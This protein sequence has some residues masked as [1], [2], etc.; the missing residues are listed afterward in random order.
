MK[1]R[2]NNKMSRNN[3]IPLFSVHIPKNASKEVSKVIESGDINRGDKVKEFEDLF[4]QM[5]GCDYALAVNSC[6]SALRLAYSLIDRRDKNGRRNIF[7]RDKVVTTPYTMVATNTAMME[8]GFQPRFADIQY[9]TANIDP[10]DIKRKIDESTKAI[11]VVHYAGYLCDWRDV[12]EI[13]RQHELLL[14]EDCAHALGASWYGTDIASLQSECISNIKC[15]S[16]QAIKHITTCGDGGM[17]VTSEK[18]LYE[19]AKTKAWFGI[20]KD[21]R[22]DSVLGKYPEDITE[23]GFKMRMNDISATMGIE[24]L[25]EFDKIFS[26]RAKTACTYMEELNNIK[27]IKLMDYNKPRRIHANWLFPIHVNRRERF[28]YEMRKKGIEVAVHNWRN[29][30]YTVFGGRENLPNTERVN[31]DL[32]H[33]PL[34]AELT[35]E[36][37]N[38]IIETIKSL[39]W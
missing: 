24:G 36:E 26:R 2:V 5:F 23:L 12:E 19:E 34:H 22:V 28:A 27:D 1:K 3:L 6:T 7:P 21:K 4:C 29:D 15:F 35:D 31:N 17:F 16:F 30:Y 8:E 20:D 39:K 13:C 32:I 14:I 9:D 37:V 25:K 18:G 33:I 11:S 10:I 38:Y